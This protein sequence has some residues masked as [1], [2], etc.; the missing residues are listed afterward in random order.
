MNEFISK[1]KEEI[2]YDKEIYVDDIP[3]CN[4]CFIEIKKGI[5]LCISC[6][7]N[8]CSE[9]IRIHISDSHKIFKLKLKNI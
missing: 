2:F 6:K 4:G 1:S 7:L 9:H 3:L 5:F 8:C